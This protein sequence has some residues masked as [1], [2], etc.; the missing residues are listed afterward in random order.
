[1][2]VRI[3]RGVQAVQAGIVGDCVGEQDHFRSAFQGT[4][5]TL[6]PFLRKPGRREPSHLGEAARPLR[7]R[8]RDIHSIGGAPDIFGFDHRR[9]VDI[10][11]GAIQD[12]FRGIRGIPPGLAAEISQSDAGQNGR[13]R[14]QES[15]FMIHRK[16]QNEVIIVHRIHRRRRRDLL[17][18][19]GALPALGR[20]PRF[21]QRRQEH[22]GENRDDGYY[23]N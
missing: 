1:M 2:S 7:Q 21:V 23:Y 20:R 22:G 19:T 9:L 16:R 5:F 11:I 8:N 4:E 17:Q 3:H 14:H 10:G 6:G 12:R 18:V 13:P 15:R